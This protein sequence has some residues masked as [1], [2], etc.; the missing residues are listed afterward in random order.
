MNGKIPLRLSEV[1][2]IP[3]FGFIFSIDGFYSQPNYSNF[4]IATE[5]DLEKFIKTI[6]FD[7]AVFKR[8][9]RPWET[10]EKNIQETIT[11]SIEEYEELKKFKKEYKEAVKDSWERQRQEDARRDFD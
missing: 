7:Y 2:E 5:E 11:I 3:N 4:F 6:K 8:E 10:I 1:K 9:V